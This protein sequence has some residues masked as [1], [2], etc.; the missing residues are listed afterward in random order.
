VTGSGE[1]GRTRLTPNRPLLLTNAIIGGSGRCA[2]AFNLERSQQN[3]RRSA[4]SL[5]CTDM[6]NTLLE[7]FVARL[8]SNVFFGEFAF[9]SAH[10][11]IPGRGEVELADHLVLLDDIGLIFQ[12]KERDES[13]P[14]TAE[15]LANWFKAKVR[16]KAVQQVG[17]T[18]RMLIEHAGAAIPNDRGEPVLLP[19]T[20]PSHVACVV[21]Y[22]APAHPSFQPPRFHVSKTA[23]FVH[24]IHADDYLGVCQALATPTEVLDYLT[25]REQAVPSIALAPAAVPEAALV[26]QFM[27]GDLS[28]VP[29]ARFAGVIDALLDDR[30]DWDLSFLT[31][32]LGSKIIFIEGSHADNSHHRILAEL[33]KLS[34]SELGEIKARLRLTL[35]AVERDELRLPYRFTSPR[36]GCGF[37]LFPVT[38]ALRSTYRIALNNYSIAS[39]HEQALTKHI[40]AAVMKHGSSIDIVWAFQAGPHRPN[41]DVDALLA[42]NY[43]FRPLRE[44]V[45]PRYRFDSDGLRDALGS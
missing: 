12:L 41:P 3:A 17:D 40:S 9:P 11:K 18:R 13:A 36:T 45:K 37:L 4:D 10:L 32:Q 7:Q 31:A 14:S 39:K 29:N 20:P 25:F 44:A 1:T 30:D 23:G 19:L 21:V 22:A 5:W 26:G 8:N 28:A 6:N 38:T 24:F 15:A 42:A 2:A 16:R 33:A 27:G 43:P 34:R 35:E